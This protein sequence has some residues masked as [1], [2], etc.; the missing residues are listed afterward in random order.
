M[1]RKHRLS[2]MT[3]R[4]LKEVAMRRKHLDIAVVTASLAAIAVL[5]VV[6]VLHALE[7][8][9]LLALIAIHTGSAVALLWFM[10][11]EGVR[12]LSGAR[13]VGSRH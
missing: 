9:M 2:K 10:I 5:L 13:R 11:A 6:G 8:R 1:I 4:H 3:I 12:S 7:G